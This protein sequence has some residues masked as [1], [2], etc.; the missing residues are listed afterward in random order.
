MRRALMAGFVTAVGAVGVVMSGPA[1][2]EPP[3]SGPA[4]GGTK[5][6]TY[7]KFVF[8]VPESWPVYDLARE[9][10][11]CVR[12]DVHAVYLGRPGSDQDCPARVRGHTDAVL[13]EPL[14]AESG[15]PAVRHMAAPDPKMDVQESVS[16]QQ[17]VAIREAHVQMTVTYGDRKAEAQRIIRSGRIA[18][19]TGPSPAP[20]PGSPSEPAGRM[21]PMAERHAMRDPAPPP[22]PERVL[23][24][25]RAYGVGWYRMPGA[26]GGPSATPAPAV[27]VT[28]TVT[29]PRPTSPAPPTE[30]VLPKPTIS[31]SPSPLPSPSPAKSQEKKKYSAARLTGRGFDTCTAPSLR[32]MRAWRGAFQAA[33]IYIGGAAR[34]CGDGNL[35]KSWV[36]AA[37]KA[38]WRLI[39]T[40]VGLQAPCNSFSSKI[41]TRKA[42]AQGRQSAD[43]AIADATSFG[44]PERA[45][46]YFDMEGYDNTKSWCTNAV[47]KFLDGW[48]DRLHE[49]GHVAGVYGSVSSTITDLGRSSGGTMPDG[50]WFAHW[51]G[52]ATTTSSYM[53]VTWWPNRQRIKQYRGTHDETHGG[54]RMSIDSNQV[55][56]FVY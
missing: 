29:V 45:P 11:R 22:R 3:P 54:V 10:D 15:A 51:D 37:R 30:P 17:R 44:L 52:R 13:V 28:K 7:G 18:H 41:D 31:Y 33:N 9:P 48:T 8:D 39:P 26:S 14:R 56:G 5:P 6:V 50:V 19:R 55:D 27:T 43:D 1:S 20:S 36:K 47:L 2:G 40:Y 38:G 12:F 42:R 4:A 23:G 53:S 49:R 21:S 24:W 34:A 16:R 25:S 46:L 35:S 32:S